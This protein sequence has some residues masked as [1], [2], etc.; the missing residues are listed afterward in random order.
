MYKEKQCPVCGKAFLPD[1]ARMKYCSVECRVT[2]T[3]QRAELEKS[4]VTRTCEWCGNE[5]HPRTNTQRYCDNVHYAVCEV[6]GKSY[7]IDL[8]KQDKR[9]TCSKECSYQLRFKDGNPLSDPTVRKKA[10]QTLIEHYGVDHPMHSDEIKSKQRATME[11]RYGDWFTRTDEYRARAEAT[12]RARYNADWFLQTDEGKQK[13]RSAYQDKYGVDNAIDVPGAKARQLA[14]VRARYGTDYV[15]QS[16]SFKEKRKAF[17]LYNYGT[18]HYSKTDEYRDKYQATMLVRYGVDNPGK[19]Y[20]IRNKIA[21]TNLAKYGVRS[22]LACRHVR[23]K[24]VVTSLQKYGVSQFSKSEQWKREHVRDATKLSTWLSFSA[25]PSTFIQ[26][27]DFTPTILQLSDMCGVS[28]ST[29]K[30]KLISLGLIGL[31]QLHVSTMEDAVRNLI[32]SWDSSLTIQ[33]HCRSIITPQEID[34]YLPQ[35]C[36]GIELNPT[37][38]H[39]SSCADVWGGDP[40]SVNY[41]LDKTKKCEAAG[42][43]LLH[44]FGPEWTHKREIVTSMIRNLIGCNLRKVYAR[45]C[46]VSEIPVDTCNSFLSVNHLFGGADAVV[47]FGLYYQEE[48]VSVMSFNRSTDWELTRF[49]SLLDTTVVGGVSKLFT[50]FIRTADPVRVVASSN[51]AYTQSIVYPLLGFSKVTET[52]PHC[53]WVNIN[54]D[55]VYD[56][57]VDDNCVQL[58][59]SGNIVWGWHK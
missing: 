3:K 13:L 25:D 5:F 45:N 52:D 47:A 54:T 31:V 40:K 53:R 21:H 42:V 36:I 22:V 6:C 41:H 28:E 43:R 51:R 58:F 49:C 39:N 26:A 29:V 34:I 27:L 16:D 19:S 59:D 7:E 24:G 11:A 50:H 10:K 38:T 2:A 8:R 1:N 37:V 17:M 32:L 33:M 46:R 30:D 35:R 57:Q 14:T 56:S 9:R 4:K 12:N 18:D 20:I 48:L 15:L 23:D 55:V 44:V